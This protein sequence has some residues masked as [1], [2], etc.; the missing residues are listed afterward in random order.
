MPGALAHAAGLAAGVDTKTHDYVRHATLTLFASLN[1]LEGKLITRPA[2]RDR[3]Q[4]W[5]AFHR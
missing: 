4:E 3:H 2:A 5:L 1:Y